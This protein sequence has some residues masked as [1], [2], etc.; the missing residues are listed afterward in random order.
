MANWFSPSTGSFAVNDQIMPAPAP[1]MY[2]PGSAVGPIYSSGGYSPLQ[3]IPQ[4][5]VP[6]A[7]SSTG[8]SVMDGSG[9]GG[10]S[11]LLPVVILLVMFVL[12]YVWLDKVH[13]G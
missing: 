6:G 8:A 12:G 3:T 2:L 5:L 4:G 11:Y 9:S 10:G 1:A 7:T 13:W